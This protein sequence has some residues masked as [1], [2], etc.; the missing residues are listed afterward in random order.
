MRL[1]V[2]ALLVSCSGE[3]PYTRPDPEICDDGADNDGDGLVDCDDKSDCGGIACRTTYTTDTAPDLPD[4]EV[5]F[6]ED[7]C[8]DFTYS[9]ADC[10]QLE[11]GSITFINRSGSEDG[12]IDVSC[13]DVG[14]NSVPAIQWAPQ[15]S[16]HPSQFI[17]NAPIYA[18]ETVVM[19]AYFVCGGGV[20]FDFTTQCVSDIEV[21]VAKDTYDWTLSATVNE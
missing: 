3:A 21:G 16:T 20:N 1:W 4:A 13:N 5:L 19:D 2:G 10:P 14:P 18:G 8:C 17:I 6:N 12:Q 15:G 11:I 9:S 7:D